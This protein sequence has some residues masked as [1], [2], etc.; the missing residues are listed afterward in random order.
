MQAQRRGSQTEEKLAADQGGQGPILG[1]VKAATDKIRTVISP[2]RFD[3][4]KVADGS[5][6]KIGTDGSANAIHLGEGGKLR[7]SP[8]FEPASGWEGTWKIG[9]SGELYM[10]MLGYDHVVSPKKDDNGGYPAMSV[11]D[12]VDHAQYRVFL[13]G[14]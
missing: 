11:H 10:S 6:V 13:I 12:G 9:D 14:K 7:E 2:D 4:Y 1:A 5:L 8:V 3:G